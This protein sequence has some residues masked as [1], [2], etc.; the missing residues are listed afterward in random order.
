VDKPVAGHVCTCSEHRV[1]EAA[2]AGYWGSSN[3]LMRRIDGLAQDLYFQTVNNAFR[4]IGPAN[5]VQWFHW[6]TAQDDRVCPIC[7]SYARGGRNGYYPTNLFMPKMP[8]HKN[9]R[10]LIELVFFDPF[11]GNPSFTVKEHHLN[12]Q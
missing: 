10:C 7:L 12:V 3:G 8:V 1:L 9:D 4:M 6:V 5:G 11:N 2:T